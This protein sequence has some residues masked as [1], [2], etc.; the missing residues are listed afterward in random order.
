MQTVDV[1]SLILG[2]GISGL[3]LLNVLRKAGFSA[4]LIHD[5]AELGGIQTLN[6]AGMVHGGLKYGLGSLRQDHE[7]DAMPGLWQHCLQGSGELDLRG[8]NLAAPEQHLWAEPELAARAGLFLA[9]HLQSGRV[10]RLSP[11]ARPS[12]LQHPAFKGDVYSLGHP[13]IDTPSLVRELAAPHADCIYQAGQHDLHIE[14][15]DRL[16]SKA[17]FIR[18][19]K[20]QIRIH[21]RQVFLT[22]GA[23]N[24]A[25]LQD[26]GV[27]QPLMVRKPVHMTCVAHQD[28]PAIFGHCLGAARRPRL[29]LTTHPLHG[30]NMWY[31]GGDVA[32]EGV[33]R[34]ETV[35]ID[36]VKRELARL[37]PWVDLKGARYHTLMIDRIYPAERSLR[38]PIRAHVEQ[39]GNNWLIWPTRLILAPDAARQV[40]TGLVKTGVT[41]EHS[42]PGELPLARPVPGVPLWEKLF[43]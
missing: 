26:I 11:E 25:L 27:N 7:L 18:K 23:G 1:D 37:L 32:E 3:W 31:I 39:I 10:T 17:V 24:G 12:L 19:G 6:S 28:L 15:G 4:L 16:D 42:Q 36:A 33:D 2:G 9:A 35:Q 20:V 41:P 38:T 8:V 22:G 34:D 14:T 40:M 29:T 13:V 5:A 30:G 43:R 21:P